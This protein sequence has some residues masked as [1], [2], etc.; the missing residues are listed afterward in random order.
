MGNLELLLV[1]RTEELRLTSLLGG[2]GDGVGEG[3]IG[4]VDPVFEKAR[5]LLDCETAAEE[6]L[7]LGGMLESFEKEESRFHAAC[8]TVLPQPET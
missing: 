2:F 7:G 5:E 6:G 8:V 4:A 3:N 1:L